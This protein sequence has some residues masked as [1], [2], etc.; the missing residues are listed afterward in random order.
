MMS[1]RGGFCGL[2]AIVAVIVGFSTPG[3]H[4]G[5]S[6]GAA[7]VQHKDVTNAGDDDY[8]FSL[9]KSRDDQV[10]SA[11]L[12]RLNAFKYGVGTGREPPYCDLPEDDSIPGFTRLSR[13]PLPIDERRRLIREVY[14]F[15][16]PYSKVPLTE[17]HDF[18]DSTKIEGPVWIYSPQIDI[19]N[20]G[21]PDKVIVWRGWGVD[22]GTQSCGIPYKVNGGYAWRPAQQ[23]LLLSSDGVSI[24][25]I[26]TNEIFGHD[27]SSSD[28]NPIGRTINVFK[29]NNKY[30][31]SAFQYGPASFN[32]GRS[33]PEIADSLIVFM[34]VSGKT[35]QL[36]EYRMRDPELRRDVHAVQ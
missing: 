27:P 35:Q 11:Y 33:E 23:V 36:C 3:Y 29:F 15:T 17:E 12:K 7:A 31:F 25:T 13:I 9:I 26:R 20:D 28:F 10:C 2:L 8:T 24:D 6:F 30:Y 18:F 4:A 5:S 34:R 19:E 21:R 14:N 22:V 1:Y 16:H 32:G